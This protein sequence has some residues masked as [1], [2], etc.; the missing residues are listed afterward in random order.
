MFLAYGLGGLLAAFVTWRGPMLLQWLPLLAVLG[1]LGC[2]EFA[3][4]EQPTGVSR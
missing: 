4:T 2:Y 1:A 3:E